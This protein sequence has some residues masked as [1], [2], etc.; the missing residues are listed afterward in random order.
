MKAKDFVRQH[1]LKEFYIK[2][3]VVLVIGVLLYYPAVWILEYMNTTPVTKVPLFIVLIY[4]TYFL[5]FTLMSALTDLSNYQKSWK[6]I[7]N[8]AEAVG[9]D[10]YLVAVGFLEHRLNYREGFHIYASGYD[11]DAEKFLNELDKAKEGK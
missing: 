4:A 5:M 11:W 3:L 8:Y 7:T 10:P 6:K 9:L 1:Y 2:L